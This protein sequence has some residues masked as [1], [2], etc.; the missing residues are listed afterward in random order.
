MYFSWSDVKISDSYRQDCLAEANS[1]RLSRSGERASSLFSRF[2]ARAL[3]QLG[4][5]VERLGRSLQ[6]IRYGDGEDLSRLESHG[7][8]YE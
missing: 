3:V 7:A 6:G 5:W 8:N 2:I 4:C 1:Q